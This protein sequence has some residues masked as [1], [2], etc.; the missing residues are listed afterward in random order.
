MINLIYQKGGKGAKLARPVTSREEYFALRNAPE[1]AKSFYDA[2]GGDETAKGNQIQF[3]YNDLLPDGVLKGC[4]HPSSTFAHDI[5]CGDA[6][7]QM[8]LKDEILAKKDEIGAICAEYGDAY[9][10]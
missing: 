8:R 1:N 6:Q 4:K 9:G 10:I 3:N 5:D 2:R 7:E